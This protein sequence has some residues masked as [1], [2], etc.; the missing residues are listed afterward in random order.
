MDSGGR[1]EGKVREGERKNRSGEREIE[2]EAQREKGTG[3]V[4][5]PLNLKYFSLCPSRFV[6]RR[7]PNFNG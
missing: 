7:I 5:Y 6:L 2:E 1:R 3:V 4:L